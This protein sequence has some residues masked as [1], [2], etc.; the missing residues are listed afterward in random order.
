MTIRNIL[1]NRDMVE[2]SRYIEASG[3]VV[4]DKMANGCCLRKRVFGSHLQTL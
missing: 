4:I 2:I 3:R 1:A